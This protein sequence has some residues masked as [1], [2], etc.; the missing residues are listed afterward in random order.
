MTA[1]RKRPLARMATEPLET[2]PRG[3]ARRETRCFFAT[4]ASACRLVSHAIVVTP[5]LFVRSFASRS[6]KDRRTQ[7]TYRHRPLAVGVFFANPNAAAARE[8]IERFL[9]TESVSCAAAALVYADLHLDAAA[10][11]GR[12]PHATRVPR[13]GIAASAARALASGKEKLGG[14]TSSAKLAFARALRGDSADAGGGVSGSADRT[15]ARRFSEAPSSR[16]AAGVASAADIAA[17][18]ACLRSSAS[19]AS[20]FGVDAASSEVERRASADV[21]ALDAFA[22]RPARVSRLR[23]IDARFGVSRRSSR[24]TNTFLALPSSTAAARSRARPRWAPACRRSSRR[25]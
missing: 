15:S 18:A 8:Y 20:R 22:S 9:R 19:S 1:L 11:A 6:F 4:P 7:R 2:R 13:S 17:A 12:A 10:D 25:S 21:S 16:R 14:E 24:S 23:T 3:R 5:P